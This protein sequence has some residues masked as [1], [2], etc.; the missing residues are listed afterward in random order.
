MPYLLRNAAVNL[1]SGYGQCSALVR[2]LCLQRQVLICDEIMNGLD[3]EMWNKVISFLREYASSGRK[4]ITE[5]PDSEL[6]KH[7]GCVS[8]PKT[9][10]I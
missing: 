8:N 2:A 5:T 4:G 3:D 1:S 10:G 6:I 9:W 7:S